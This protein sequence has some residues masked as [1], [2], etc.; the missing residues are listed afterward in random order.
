MYELDLA[1]LQI[2]PAG[3][4]P[5]TPGTTIPGDGMFDVVAP[6]GE[7]FIYFRR[8]SSTELFRTMAHWL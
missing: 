8:H 6:T 4:A 5:Y 1:T 2:I 3:T 7:R